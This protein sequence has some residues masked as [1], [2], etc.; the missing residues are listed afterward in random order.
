MLLS[1]AAA[2]S[3][4]SLTARGAFAA[5]AAAPT[6]TSVAVRFPRHALGD[7]SRPWIKD[8]GQV[9]LTRSCCVQVLAALAWP[10]GYQTGDATTHRA[11]AVAAGYSVGTGAG[12]AAMALAEATLPQRPESRMSDYN[13]SN[14]D[15]QQPSTS[16]RTELPGPRWFMEA[17]GRSVA[18]K[19]D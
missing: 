19:G 8:P 4:S 10:C 2:V 14:D 3:I 17:R 7:S 15:F 9:V 16:G 6:L 13:S 5:P 18:A 12:T 11:L 1:A